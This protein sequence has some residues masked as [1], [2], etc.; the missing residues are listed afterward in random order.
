MSSTVLE[1]VTQYCQETGLPAPT[2][3][4]GATDSH[5]QNLFGIL[6]KV[7]RECMEYRWSDLNKR[8]TWLSTAGED[9]GPLTTVFGPD[10]EAQVGSTF[11]DETLRRPIYGPTPDAEWEVF[12]ALQNP[13]P[14]YRYA[15]K[16]GNIHITPT[17]P[18]GH[19]LAVTYY[20]N[21]PVVTETTLVRKPAITAD[22]DTLVFSDTVVLAGFDWLWKKSKGE[23]WENDRVLWTAKVYKAL[24]KN[25]GPTLRLDR[26]DPIVRPGIIVPAGNWM[27]P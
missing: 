13:G 16:L 14:F 2:A 1:L 8:V 26:P 21:Y 15:V 22:T 18:A 6:K 17:M 23:D 25:L 9:Q 12:K 4:V 19:T 3:L 24:G 7:I 5:T 20:S 10:Y 27:V 11:W